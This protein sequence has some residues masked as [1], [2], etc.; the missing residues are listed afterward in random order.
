MANS[1]QTVIFGVIFG[2]LGTFLDVFGR[3]LGVWRG[4]LRHRGVSKSNL[5]EPKCHFGSLGRH[6]DRHWGATGGYL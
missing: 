6:L 4:T 2:A 5:G 3:L 1:A